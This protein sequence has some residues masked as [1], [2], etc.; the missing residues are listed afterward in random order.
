MIG[1]SALFERDSNVVYVIRAILGDWSWS[2][3]GSVV[4]SA[5]WLDY[6]CQHIVAWSLVV[7]QP[8]SQ[9][10]N[11]YTRCSFI[12]TSLTAWAIARSEAI[13]TL[14]CSLLF[15][16]RWQLE[17]SQGAWSYKQAEFDAANNCENPFVSV[18][19]LCVLYIMICAPCSSGDNAEVAALLAKLTE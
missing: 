11:L 17:R 6:D 2:C 15:K 12:Q 19:V 14:I 4:G 16:H 3:Q 1:H 10:S 9:P 18:F 7:A 5:L 8:R 13:S